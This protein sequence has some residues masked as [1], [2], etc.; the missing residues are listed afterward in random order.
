MEEAKGLVKHMLLV[1]FKDDTSP[2]QI[3]ELIK[4]FANL[5]NL[6]KDVSIENAHQGF[7]HVFETTFESTEGIAE[8]LPH[9]A[10]VEFSKWFLPSWRRSLWSTSS[11]LLFILKQNGILPYSADVMLI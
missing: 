1:R 6:G 7:N 4:G 5:I 10:H 11:Q 2:D 8:Y 9:P 3:E